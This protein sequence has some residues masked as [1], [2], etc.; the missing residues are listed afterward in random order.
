MSRLENP[1][2]ELKDSN[3]VLDTV[4]ARAEAAEEE[5]KK[6]QSGNVSSL[7]TVLVSTWPQNYRSRL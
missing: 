7:F 4:M 1:D 5:V 3:D 6:Y 2:G